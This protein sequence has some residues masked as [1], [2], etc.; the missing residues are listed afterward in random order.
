MHHALRCCFLKQMTPW[1]HG[2]PT[3]WHPQPSPH[4]PYSH[5]YTLQHRCAFAQSTVLTMQT[6]THM[7][8]P[9]KA[10]YPHHHLA[11]QTQIY[12]Q[13]LLN[14]LN[15]V[16]QIS[17]REPDQPIRLFRQNLT[18]F[19]KTDSPSLPGQPTMQPGPNTP[20]TPP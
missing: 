5:F 7:Q 3:Q 10:T 9:P 18:S 19:F 2:V 13:R 8:W 20:T 6:Q 17:S 16:F 15:E 12:M 11:T 4:V 14:T 1:C